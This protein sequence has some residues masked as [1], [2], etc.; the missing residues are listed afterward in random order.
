MLPL[1]SK[2]HKSAMKKIVLP[3][4]LLLLSMSTIAE[5]KGKDKVANPLLAAWNTPF[6]TPPFEQF[7][8]EHYVPAFHEIIATAKKQVDGIVASKAAPTFENTVVALERCG[9]DIERVANVFFNLNSAETNEQLQAVAREVAP[10]L[11]DFSND[12][13]LNPALF[14]KVKAV[15]DRRGTLTLDDEQQM[16]LE[17]TYKGF[18]RSGANLNETGK[19]RFRQ[20]SKE[21]SDL[22]LQFDENVLAENNGFV[23]HI[24]SEAD[25]AGIPEGVREMAK[26]IAQAKSLDGWA[27]D[28]SMPSYMAFMKYADNRELRE[29]LFRAYGSRGFQDNKNNNQQIVAK[30]ANLRLE[31]A[32][33]LG[34][35]SY[36]D[37]VLEERM[38]QN[39]AKVNG[40]LNQLLSASLPA[41][42]KEVDE[43]TAFAKESGA[44]FELQRWDWSYYSEKLK[45][46]KYSVNDELVKPYFQLAKVRDGV[47]ELA[48][49]LYGISFKKNADIPVYNKDVEAYEVYDKDGKFLSVLYM[50]YYPR[51][52][53]SGG[54]WMTNYRSQY[55]DGKAD[56]RPVVS[57][58]FNFNKPTESRP[59]LLTFSEL[60]TFLHEFGH[61]LHGMFASGK[62]ASLSGTSVY[63]DFVEL[64]SQIMENWAVEKEFLDMFAEHYQ[65][66][67][68]IPQELVNKIKQ[69]ANFQAG[70]ASLRQLSFGLLD[71][72]WHSQLVPLTGNVVAFERAATSATDILP[73]V[74]GTAT[75]P[76]FSH[77]FAGGYAAG[78]YGYK[79]AEV[80]DAD[81]YSLFKKNGIF[82]AKTAQ[83]FRDNI[84]SKGGTL[85][86]MKL[87]VKF[88]GLEPTV[89]ALLA[90]SGLKN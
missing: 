37:Y 62:Y 69:S 34:Y 46:K 43:V 80:L 77:I 54:A 31:M 81:A 87:Y 23:L 8:P 9:E 85:H 5:T 20:I 73:A 90:R 68:K 10:L 27:F 79:W 64:P 66:G 59:S 13:N 12:I 19:D 18:V 11:S 47:L 44:R 15:Y 21:L 56:V 86:P 32:Q 89:D 74:D 50:D 53:K 1:I 76:A 84:L 83:S 60:E 35:P 49:K 82:D 52:S 48:G 33:L 72:A 6:Q 57:L 70:Y 38:A 16:L 75:S 65:T 39:A 7:K 2:P 78:Y 14:A 36:A 3:T 28:L 63:R 17:K 25:L 40:L 55:N 4:I 61:G 41:G 26:G 71:M 42:K 29:K 45:D 22:S 51:A 30:T 88:R 58:V 24:A 67:E